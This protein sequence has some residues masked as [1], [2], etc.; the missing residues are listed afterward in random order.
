M[1]EFRASFQ[2]WLADAVQIAFAFAFGA[3]LGSLTNV[4]VY[5]LPLG[6]DVVTPSSRCPNCGVKLT[7][8]EN[9]PVFG[10]LFLRGRCRFCWQKISPEYPIVEAAVGLLFAVSYWLWYVVEPDTSLLGL[11]VGDIRPDYAYAEFKQTWPAWVV[12]LIALTCAFAMALTDLKTF[13]VPLVLAWVSAGLGIM[14]HP[15]HALAVELTWGRLRDSAPGYVWTIPTPDPTN[16]WWIGAAIGGMVGVGVGNVLLSLGLIRRS[17]ADYE[18]WESEA[19]ARQTAEGLPEQPDAPPSDMWIRYPYARREMVKELAFLAPALGL[20][21]LG[22]WLA[23]KLMVPSAL[24]GGDLF[25]LPPQIEHA[26]L[27][28]TALTGALMGYLIGGGVVWLVRI[29]GSLGFGKEAIGLGD[30]HLMAGVGACL[31]WIDAVL[32]FFT[33]AFVGLA[34]EVAGRSLLGQRRKAMP[35][36]PCL[37]LAT[38]L[39]VF[40]KPVYEAGL[41]ALVRG[42]LHLP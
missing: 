28:L 36:V 35:F 38:L 15:L 18:Q 26:P 10:W 4:L 42:V 16:W 2:L 20:G 3:C 29:L 25:G 8:R 37:T 40:G 14:A 17:F 33:A 21:M 5:R 22:G 34:W 39:V 41:G 9:I 7:W 23:K 30:V 11:P 31:G 27:W 19:K 6:L 13:T 24:A 1:D 12:M 32:A